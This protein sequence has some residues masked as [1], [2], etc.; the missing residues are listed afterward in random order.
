MKPALSL[1]AIAAVS[2]FHCLSA[3]S[4]PLPG[5]QTTPAVKRMHPPTRHDERAR[6]RTYNATHPFAPPPA[7]RVEIPVIKDA[8]ISS[9]AALE[10]RLEIEYLP[11]PAPPDPPPVVPVTGGCLWLFKEEFQL[12]QHGLRSTVVPWTAVTLDCPATKR[13]CSLRYTADR[14]A[15]TF[16]FNKEFFALLGRYATPTRLGSTNSPG[17]GLA[18]PEKYEIEIIGGANLINSV[19]RRVASEPIVAVRNTNRKWIGGAVLT[20]TVPQT[21]AGSTLSSVGSEVA[22]NDD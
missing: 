5:S 13:T 16:K 22:D 2:V 11:S 19:K 8:E 15:H 7:R 21:R 18:A 14:R 1:A 3:T 6:P 9:A 17:F 4:Q 10:V 12:V 20:F